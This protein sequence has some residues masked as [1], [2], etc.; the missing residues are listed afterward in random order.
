[1]NVRRLTPIVFALFV[2]AAAS[3]SGQ[4]LTPD[5]KELAAY[6]LTM[7]TVRK[8]AAVMQRLNDL[9]SKNPK[10]QELA[11]VRAE[12]EAL[13]QKDELTEADEQRLERLREREEVL[14]EEIDRETG[15]GDA[16]SIDDIVKRVESQLEARAALAQEG[17]TAREFAKTFLALLQA[18]MVKGFSQG[19]VDMAKLPA[20]INPENIKF[21][22]EHEKELAAIQAAMSGQKK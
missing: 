14:D 21:V 2:A 5:Q 3:V 9:E 1:M 6:A 4:A 19:Q 7:P 12:I 20:G 16:S 17:L 22:E 15:A 13:E 11:K 10:V 8:V 18:A